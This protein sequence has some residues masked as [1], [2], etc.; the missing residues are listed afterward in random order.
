MG[1]YTI[2]LPPVQH[3][4][5]QQ[6]RA[7][8]PKIAFKSLTTTM[9]NQAGST[10]SVVVGSAAVALNTACV[11]YLHHAT[12]TGS[13]PR[14][15]YATADAVVNV[16]AGLALICDGALQ[17]S[18]DRYSSSCS[19][20]LF[21]LWILLAALS[22]AMLNVGPAL[23]VHRAV[24]REASVLTS[25]SRGRRSNYRWSEA[26]RNSLP[27]LVS[28]IAWCTAAIFFLIAWINSQHDKDALGVREAFQ[29][30]EHQ[31]QR[32]G[33]DLIQ[34]LWDYNS[35]RND[36][37]SDFR[38][39]FIIG[40]VQGLVSGNLTH[41]QLAMLNHHNYSKTNPHHHTID[42]NHANGSTIR[43][44]SSTLQNWSED[45][46][47]FSSGTKE[48]QAIKN[49]LQRMGIANEAIE[50]VFNSKAS[51]LNEN[52]PLAPERNPPQAVTETFDLNPRLNIRTEI[53]TL[54][55]NPTE[56]G[57]LVPQNNAIMNTSLLYQLIQR[58]SN[59][60]SLE[61]GQEEPNFI[62]LRP[63][64]ATVITLLD[65]ETFTAQE[66]LSTS[67][68]S[69]QAET[70]SEESVNA[71]EE[72]VNATAESVN[73]TEESV[74]ATEESVNTTEESVNATEESVNATEE[75]VNATE[76]SVVAI[77]GSANEAV[78]EQQVTTGDTEDEQLKRT[79][80]SEIEVEL[81]T[82]WSDTNSTPN[83]TPE[84]M[85]DDQVNTCY[86][87]TSFSRGFTTAV[88]VVMFCAPVLAT[89]ALSGH[90]LELLASQKS[91]ESSLVSGDGQRSP[92]RSRGQAWAEGRDE[93]RPKDVDVN[94]FTFTT[95]FQQKMQSTIV[96]DMILVVTYIMF[97][98]P[99]LVERLVY[100]WKDRKCLPSTLHTP[101]FLLI[102]ALSHT[103]FRAIYYVMDDLKVTDK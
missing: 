20:F 25:P 10:L 98:L 100:S 9:G 2:L 92:G 86:L 96:R 77:E 62:D 13:V 57:A 68:N 47:H 46:N 24:R 34:K 51:T 82:L 64:D 38:E 79:S 23:D 45:E 49:L 58:R 43:E 41:K 81:T 35:E 44:S 56:D 12:H 53:P 102:L 1:R 101:D 67:E 66:P 50:K 52:N 99:L 71:T 97:W 80:V 22:Y 27:R 55:D 73:A 95:M 19:R 85:N 74:N 11:V 26:Q 89:L 103:I 3:L 54:Q 37:N 76:E 70:A 84:K 94:M 40:L 17:L 90:S 15:F 83:S 32:E 31:R 30:R 75:S 87:K 6:M 4:Q 16:I 69:A 21:L 88:F 63:N 7:S 5:Q 36:W 29:W 72:S 91:S 42:A 39:N 33:R 93:S 60:S 59:S 48:Q 8:E 61:D 18:S 78:Q 65:Q 14:I 28:G